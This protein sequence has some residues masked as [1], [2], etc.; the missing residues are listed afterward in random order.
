[1]RAMVLAAG[2]GERMRPLT[3]VTPKP[4]LKVG[5]ETL[6]ERHL[7]ALRRAGIREIVVNAAWLGEQLRARL[8]DGGRFDVRIE[9]S[10]EPPGALETGGGIRRALDR[11]GDAPFLVVNGDVWTD[12]DFAT[13]H[14]PDVLADDDVA[15]LVLVPT[16]TYK[17]HHDFALD[18]SRIVAAAPTHTFSGIGVYRRALFDDAPSRA[19]FP[20]TPLL[21]AAVADHT[22]AGIVHDGAW[23]DVGTP[24]RLAALDARLRGQSDDAD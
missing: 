12:L 17:P 10:E 9:W 19:R 4:L 3:D 24:E 5:G 6:I 13:L 21:R 15:A 7:R 23:Y 1:M 14:R 20:L 22:V 11:L 8:G 2:R 16:P 18:G